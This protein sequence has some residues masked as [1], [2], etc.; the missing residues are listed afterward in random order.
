MTPFLEQIAQHFFEKHQKELYKYRF[1]LPN[2]RASLFFMHYLRS[3]VG[4][5]PLFAPR[6]TTLNEFIGTASDLV[7]GEKL[8]L[9]FELYKCYTARLSKE[10]AEEMTFESFYQIGELILQDFQDIDKHHIDARKLFRNLYELKELENELSYLDEAQRQAISSF[11]KPLPA[12]VEDAKPLL[13]NFLNFWD[14]LYDLYVDYKQSLKNLGIGY[15]GMIMRDICDK[16]ESED[17]SLGD[18]GVI[19]VFVGLNA[20]T[21]C[22]HRILKHLKESSQ[23]LFYWDYPSIPLKD[24]SPAAY[25]REYNLSHYPE[26]TGTDAIPREDIKTFPKIEVT[27]IPSSIAQTAYIGADLK[28][29]HSVQPESMQG[30]R[31]AVVLPNERLLIPMLSNI[32]IEVEHLNVTM[33]Y[34][35][36]ET[37][38]V[39]LLEHLLLSLNKQVINTSSDDATWRGADVIQIFS[40]SVLS[41]YIGLI[42]EKVSE[43]IIRRKHVSITGSELLSLIKEAYDSME[44]DAESDT[45]KLLQ[46]IFMEPPKPEDGLGL[47][48]YFIRLLRFLSDKSIEMPEDITEWSKDTASTSEDTSESNEVFTAEKAILP[49]LLLLI[50]EMR[51]TLV[52]WQEGVGDHILTTQIVS[53]VLLTIWRNARIP[54]TGE[55]LRGLQ[56]MGVLETRGLDFDIIYI[57]DASEGTLPQKRAV[58]GIIPYSLRLG[59]GLPTYEWQDRTRAYNFFRLISRAKR[60]I[61]TYDSRKS[62]ISQGEPSRYIRMLHY[63]YGADVEFKSANYPLSPLRRIDSG[64]TLRPQLI[65][66]Y[67]KDLQ[68]PES[69]IALSPSRF[70]TFVRCPRQFYYTVI[71]GISDQEKLHER[72]ESNDLGTIVHNTLEELYRY[73]IERYEGIIDKGQLQEWLNKANT[74]VRNCTLRHFR[75]H[76][77]GKD[78]GRT[79]RGYNLIQYEYAVSQ[80]LSIIRKD[81]D[82]P[83][84]LKY[85]GGEMRITDALSLSDGSTINVKGFID[86]VDLEGDCLRIIDYKTGRDSYDISTNNAQPLAYNGA[87]TQLLFYCHVIRSMS[88]GH[89]F[90]K[91]LPDFRTLRPIIN[92]P[93]NRSKA[94]ELTLKDYR[95]GGKATNTLIEDYEQAREWFEDFIDT[96]LLEIIDKNQTFA[97]RPHPTT[98]RYCPA[99]DLCEATAQSTTEE[100]AEDE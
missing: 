3:Y 50:Q 72:I 26:P 95:G 25:F 100:E 63:I 77:Y 67:Q 22:E 53:D 46:L 99:Y 68:D 29:L 34:P 47:F 85:V 40:M 6:I 2:R 88:P 1:F 78:N 39:A 89:E 94:G 7:S 18:D 38:M 76:F 66:Q 48:E 52:H 65:A 13:K 16:I 28:A 10:K 54:Y 15:D 62:D 73:F 98:C 5:T 17:T 84:Q 96:L 80:V 42:R 60:V 71:C 81:K 43:L 86:R 93:H 74:D 79:P 27:A 4:D 69:G 31:V 21:P 32:P 70:K 20:L 58:T 91:K 59:Y 82:Y 41:P 49:H 23:T 55:P 64:D 83:R 11:L 56:M 14:G 37:P 36:R 75:K 45:L 30:L 24:K 19:N 12:K 8:I 57:P 35:V 97:P 90:R 87:A 44:T 92:K 51:Q 61:L 9:L 33:G